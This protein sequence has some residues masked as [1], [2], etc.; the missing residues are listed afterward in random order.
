MRADQQTNAL[1]TK[2]KDTTWEITAK[3]EITARILM[4]FNHKP[5]T[6]SNL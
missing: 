6:S 2:L 3:A 4:C 5:E 1:A